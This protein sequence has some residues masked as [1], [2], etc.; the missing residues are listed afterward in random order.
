MAARMRLISRLEGQRAFQI[1]GAALVD[2]LETA[3]GK[4]ALACCILEAAGAGE[5]AEGGGDFCI[6]LG[7]GL[8]RPAIAGAEGGAVTEEPAG[9]AVKRAAA[10][11][12]IEPAVI[13][14]LSQLAI[15][16]DGDATKGAHAHQVFF[17]VQHRQ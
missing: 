1:G 9:I 14:M 13:L 3:A 6:I 16:Q 12:K 2:R 7:I 15:R 4:T 11:G 5:L 8:D 10:L 17:V